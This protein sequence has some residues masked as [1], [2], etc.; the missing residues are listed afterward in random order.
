MFSPAFIKIVRTASAPAGEGLQLTNAAVTRESSIFNIGPF[1]Y[2]PKVH[3]QDTFSVVE[4]FQFLDIF[5]FSLVLSIGGLHRSFVYVNSK[6]SSV[7]VC[8]CVCSVAK[9]CLTLCDP[10]DCSPPG[11]SAHGIFQAKIPGELPCPSPGDFSGSEEVIA[12]HSV[13]YVYSAFQISRRVF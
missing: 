13:S 2:R 9:S 11:S 6:I 8:V 10:M 7:C 4:I 1:A 5:T 3:Y 12:K